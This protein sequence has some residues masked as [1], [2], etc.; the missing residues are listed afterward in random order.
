MEGRV[1]YNF[2]LPQPVVRLNNVD[3]SCSKTCTS[4][5]VLGACCPEN[6]EV[7]N[8]HLLRFNGEIHAKIIIGG[9]GD[10][11]VSPPNIQL[12]RL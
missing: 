6:L 5:K 10:P 4:Y 8:C 7:R 9:G 3:L 11:T 1:L 2:N 12:N